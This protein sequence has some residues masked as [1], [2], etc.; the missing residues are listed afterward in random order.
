MK[1]PCELVV[2]YIL[3]TIRKEVAKSLVN[4]HDYSQVDV[5]KSFGVTDAAVSQYLNNKRGN[6]SII[7][8]NPN[9]SLIQEKIDEAADKIA[10][11]S[12][13]A[14]VICNVCISMKEAG[15]LSK[16]YEIEFNE[17]MPECVC[18]QSSIA[19]K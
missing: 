12:E 5:A 1:I 16:I 4:R 2:W 7:T 8:S 19:L 17:P 13:L 14:D 9:Y 11:G 10:N 6:N 3:P 15:I 18:S